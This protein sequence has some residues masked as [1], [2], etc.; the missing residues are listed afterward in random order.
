MLLLICIKS[1]GMENYEDDEIYDDINEEK[2]IKNDKDMNNLN[3][4]DN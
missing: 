3:S 1:I 2:V 4:I